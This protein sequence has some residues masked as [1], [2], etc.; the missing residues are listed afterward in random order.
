MVVF[1]TLIACFLDGSGCLDIW[2]L[3]VETEVPI[4]RTQIGHSCNRL[5]WAHDGRKI[6][7]G[8]TQ[9]TLLIY[10]TGEVCVCADSVCIVC[11]VSL[12]ECVHRV[13]CEFK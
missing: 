12:P 1:Q 9:G 4:T 8:G 11:A 3:N 10:D 5:R 6:A 2:N 13:C 7:T